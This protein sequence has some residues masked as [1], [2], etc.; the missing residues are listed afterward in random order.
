VTGKRRTP[1]ISF[2]ADP[3]TGVAVYQTSPYVPHGGWE[4][5]GGTSLGTPAWAAIIA[6][7]DQG[8]ALQSK[9]SLDGATQTLPTLYALPSS[10]FNVVTPSAGRSAGTT[11]GRGS[12]KGTPVVYQMVAN[13]L[14]VPLTLARAAKTNS[15]L[16]HPARAGHRPRELHFVPGWRNRIPQ[17]RLL[18]R[19]PAAQAIHAHKPFVV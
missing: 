19:L 5:V 13:A 3:D 4:V 14:A 7:I 1:D 11:T 9:G 17:A 2:D 6:I 15:R 18:K 8:R 12:P 10:A 16:L